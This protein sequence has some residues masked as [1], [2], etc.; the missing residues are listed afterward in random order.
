MMRVPQGMAPTADV[1][2]TLTRASGSSFV[3][4]PSGTITFT[5]AN[6]DQ[7]QFVEV[8]SSVDGDTVED[9]ATLDASATGISTETVTVRVTDTREADPSVIDSAVPATDGGGTSSS[10][11][12]CGVGGSSGGAFALSLLVAS[13]LRRRRR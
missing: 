4:V 1:T 10:S 13:T 2:V 12:C 9:I 6:W 5:P 3:S 8:T 7:P 11:G